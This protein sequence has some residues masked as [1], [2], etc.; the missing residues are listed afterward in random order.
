MV[1]TPAPAVGTAIRIQRT[2]PLTQTSVWTPYSAFKAKTLEGQL[3]MLAMKDQQL[4]RQHDDLVVEAGTPD[5]P[6]NDAGICSVGLTAPSFTG[7]ASTATALTAS[8]SAWKPDG[9]WGP[10]LLASMNRSVRSR[11]LDLRQ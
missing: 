8:A 4:Q 9:A 6:C 11:Y 5:I 1:F 3:D 2:L 7:N 10:C